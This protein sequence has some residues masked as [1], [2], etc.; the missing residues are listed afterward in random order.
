[1]TRAAL[2]RVALGALDSA[3]LLATQL[4]DARTRLGESD[5]GATDDLLRELDTLRPTVAAELAAAT[6]PEAK[7]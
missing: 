2:A 1:M 5:D 3:R 6:R 4:R 7:A